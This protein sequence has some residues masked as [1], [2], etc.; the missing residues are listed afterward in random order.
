MRSS[1]LWLSV[2]VA[3]HVHAPN[4][5]AQDAVKVKVR[6]STDKNAEVKNLAAWDVIASG[7]NTIMVFR[8]QAGTTALPTIVRLDAYSADK[9]ASLGLPI[10]S[11]IHDAG[12][13]GCTVPGTVGALCLL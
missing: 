1:L 4:A 8:K 7:N 10:R 2:V 12:V 3:C 5:A 9:L 6:Q 11:A 13:T